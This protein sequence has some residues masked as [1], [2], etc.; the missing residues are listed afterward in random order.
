[1]NI[2]ATNFV[3]PPSLGN[4]NENNQQARSHDKRDVIPT[5]PKMKQ[6]VADYWVSN[7]DRRK[8]K[9]ITN[10]LELKPDLMPEEPDRQIKV[11]AS[12]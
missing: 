12:K 2:I 10:V 5:S 1:M 8:G 3:T 6:I 11:A 9:Q 4:H 7:F